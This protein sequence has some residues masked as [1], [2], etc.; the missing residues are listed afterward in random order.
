MILQTN[1]VMTDTLFMP[2]GA[3]A[4]NLIGAGATQRLTV[5]GVVRLTQSTSSPRLAP[6]VV[7]MSAIP[8]ID[9]IGIAGRGLTPDTAVYTGGNIPTLPVGVGIRYNSVRVS[10]TALM[11]LPADTIAGD[12]HLA[13]NIGFF[14]ASTTFRIAGKL[15]TTGTGSLAS[16]STDVNLTVVDS[17]I[18]AGGTTNGLLT[19]GTLTALGAFVQ[20]GGDP[21]AFSATGTFR[22]HLNG[23]GL[24]QVRFTNPGT[25]TTTSHFSDLQIGNSTAAG[26]QFLSPVFAT[27]QLL[28]QPGRPAISRI[29]GTAAD[30]LTINGILADSITFDGVPLRIGGTAALTNLSVFTFQNMNPA[31]NQ[32]T[33]TRAGGTFFPNAVTFLTVPNAGV[34]NV[35][36]TNTAAAGPFTAT[37]FNSA[38]TSTLMIGPPPRYLRLGGP[39][40]VVVWNGVTLP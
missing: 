9:P 30:S 39:P 29:F 40:A 1:A 31:V 35:V 14:A 33:I 23:T 26:I 18:F 6:P 17:T 4:S 24:Q 12:L 25:T 8:A 7:E 2:G 27:N 10:T 37:F 11:T 36:V 13:G 3:G 16:V 34:N 20:P 38:P 21:A 22:V 5:N 32:F 19:A 15:R 28:S